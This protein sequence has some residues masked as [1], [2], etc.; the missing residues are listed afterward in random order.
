MVESYYTERTERSHLRT[1]GHVSHD[2]EMQK[3]QLEID[4][5]REKLWRRKRGRRSPSPPSSD[6]SEES[7][8]HSYRHRSRTPS[9]ESFSASS[10]QDKLEKG[11][12]KHGQGSSHRSMGNDAMSKALRQI[13]KSPF[14]RRINKARLPYWFSQPT[15]TIYNGMSD[16]VEHVSHF[17][18]RMT[19]HSSN[20][21]L[22]CK[23]F[24][25]SLGLIA[26]RWFDALEKGSIRS[27]ENLTRAF[28]ARFVTCSKVPKPLDSLLSMAMR[29]GETLKTYLNRYRETYNEI[30]GDFENMVVRTFKVGLST[31]HELR[32]S[33]TM[34]PALSMHQL[35]DHIDKYKRVKE[36]QT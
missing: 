30:D 11:K 23:V 6:G 3:L 18:H 24:L 17:N 31:K 28:G 5:L 2:Q 8:D 34:K 16:P 35:M 13:S 32:K 9:R 33:L 22:M 19:V 21:A 10:H 14:A 26:M 36:D 7:K 4:Y 1:R 29:E 15:F 27:F 25:F 20:E 12:F